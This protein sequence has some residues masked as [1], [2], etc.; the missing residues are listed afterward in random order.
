MLSVFLFL[1][2]NRIQL[3][4]NGVQNDN[5]VFCVCIKIIIRNVILR[6]SFVGFGMVTSWKKLN[7]H[8][9]DF[10]WCTHL[11]YKIINNNGF[12]R[13][14]LLCTRCVWNILWH[15]ICWWATRNKRIEEQTTTTKNSFAFKVNM[16]KDKTTDWSKPKYQ[17]N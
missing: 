14:I 2:Q 4:C 17:H 7:K 10:V 5:F 1:P 15:N 3:H 16:W 11:W 9:N 8:W 6:I 12:G 13:T